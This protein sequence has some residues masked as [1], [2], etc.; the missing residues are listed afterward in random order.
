MPDS[1]A[2]YWQS[3]YDLQ[4]DVDDQENDDENYQ[5]EKVPTIKT[6]QA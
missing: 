5:S 1:D 2:S 4:E 3:E 6:S